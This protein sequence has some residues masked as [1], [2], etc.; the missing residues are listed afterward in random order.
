MDFKILQKEGVDVTNFSN[1]LYIKNLIKPR[2]KDDTIQESE[3]ESYGL[4]I[5]KIGMK[6]TEIWTFVDF[7]FVDINNKKTS[8]YID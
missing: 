3:L 8:D 5:K 1:S 2:D 4:C 6:K 7:G